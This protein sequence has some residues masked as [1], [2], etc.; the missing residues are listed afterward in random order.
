MK[1]LIASAALALLT[2][3]AAAQGG[4]DC[5][6][7]TAIAG[8]GLYSFD[9]S[10]ATTTGPADCNTR[11]ARRD[12]WWT[13][14]APV[15]ES[16]RFETCNTNTGFDTRIVVY[17]SDDCN[18]LVVADCA[19]QSCNG[20]SK[21]TFDA[22]AGQSYLLRVGSRQVGT[23]GAG[24]FRVTPDPCPSTSDDGLE[25]NDDCVSAVPATDGTYSNLWCSKADPDWYELCVAPGAT[26]NVDVLF[27]HATG[28]IDVFATDNCA[29]SSNIGVSGSANDDENITWMNA[30]TT[31]V[32]IYLRVELWD[33]DANSDCNDYS[34]VI[35]GATG[36]CTGGG[37][38]GTA[39]CTANPNSTGATAEITASGSV[40]VADNTVTLAG[41][42]LPPGMTALFLTSSTQG[43]TANP[44][45]SL[46]NLCLGGSIGRF[47][48]PGQ[49]QA[50]NGL[51]VVILPLDLTQIPEGAAFVS[52]LPGD[53]RSFQIWYR[54]IVG[55]TPVSN[56]TD[57][58]AITFQ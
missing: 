49:V 47:I 44:G 10:A 23:G 38:I 56:F 53:T 6:S 4:N 35:T 34:M 21:T 12:L 40:V 24:E 25:D 51:G 50:A 30:G 43:F 26:L 42:A 8:Y 58:T 13:W 20:L 28:D 33:Q 48:A 3:T 46:G 5:A 54:D 11:P 15:T 17:T 19:G 22:V 7:A 45:G 14:T 27:T 36:T 57:G 39:Y 52:V 31:D 29:F 1:L 2:S 41:V 37:G 16:V 18:A 9:N 32:T 55:G